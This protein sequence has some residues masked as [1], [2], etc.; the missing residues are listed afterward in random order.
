MEHYFLTLIYG[1]GPLCI[2]QRL[3][4]KC[5]EALSN[6]AFNF[7]LRRYTKVLAFVDYADEAQRAATKASHPSA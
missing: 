3:K 5:D 7:N 2:V 4:A 6:F 1:G